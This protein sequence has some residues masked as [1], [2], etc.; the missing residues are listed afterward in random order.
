MHNGDIAA[1]VHGCFPVPMAVHSQKRVTQRSTNVATSM[2]T[3]LPPSELQA[4]FDALPVVVYFLKDRQGRCTHLNQ[5]LVRRLGEHHRPHLDGKP[6]DPLVRS[7][8]SSR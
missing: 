8:V 5:T 2:D 1:Y 3:P 6:A 4:I 7:L